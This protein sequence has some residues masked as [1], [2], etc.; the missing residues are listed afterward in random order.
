MTNLDF[1]RVDL[2][3]CSP[4][5]A[6]HGTKRISSLPQEVLK[7]RTLQCVFVK[8][9]HR[10]FPQYLTQKPSLNVLFERHLPSL[11]Q[12]ADSPFIC[13]TQGSQCEA[14][15]ASSFFLPLPS[16]A[17]LLPVTNPHHTLSLS[18]FGL[19][20]LLSALLVW[21]SL[22]SFSSSGFL[23]LAIIASGN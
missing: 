14:S 16:G 8:R 6:G 5:P 2:I 13:P 4:F 23:N 19:F 17:E 10:D 11:T 15:P 9:K 1:N 21:F 18:K 7:C 22:H 3:L 12:L 20:G